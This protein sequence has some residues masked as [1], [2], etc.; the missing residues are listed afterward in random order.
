MER[1]VTLINQ[2]ISSNLNDHFQLVAAAV[3]ASQ[4]RKEPL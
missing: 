4:S 2:Q 1:P 3:S